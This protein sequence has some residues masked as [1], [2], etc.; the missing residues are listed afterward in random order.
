[1]T[2]HAYFAPS[3]SPRWLACPGSLK[4][5]EDIEES[6]SPYAHEGTVCH[7]VAARCLKE[8]LAAHDFTGC[9][10]E[11]VVM[12]RELLDG[13]QMYV[14][15]VRGMAKELGVKGGKIEHTVQIAEDCWGTIDAT[16]WNAEVLLVTDLKMGKGVIV[17]V[18]DNPQCKLYAVGQLMWLQKEHGL[19]P[20][21]VV[22]YII[23]PRTV[24]P[25][26]KWETT[27]QELIDWY[28]TTLKPTLEKIKAGDIECIPGETQCRWCPASA[29]CSV[30]AEYM[31]KETKEAFSPFSKTTA[32][33]VDPA[34]PDINIG[35]MADLKK[36][37]K[38]IQNW[39]GSIDGALMDLALGGENI[40]GFKLVRGRAN[41]KWV[42][43]ERVIEAFLLNNKVEP[44]KK[45]LVSP[46][47]AEKEFGKK[48]AKAAGFDKYI[49]TPPGKPTL[50]DESDKRPAMEQNVEKEFEQ[51]VESEIPSLVG[52]HTGERKIDDGPI[53]VESESSAMTLLERLARSDIPDDVL[54]PPSSTA[55][56]IPAI[57]AQAKARDLTIEDLFEEEK[58]EPQ[59]ESVE[60]VKAQLEKMSE[61]ATSGN[62]VDV[63][64]SAASTGK[65]KPPKTNTK[66]YQVL[67][68]GKGGV[69]LEDVAKALGCGINT[70]KMH[71]RYLHE[72]D[73]YGYEI[74]S[75]GTFKI[76]E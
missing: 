51:F 15:E 5:S 76:I 38:H 69:S 19:S 31:M 43:D 42:K 28:K 26:R 9:I 66:R 27:R 39:M 17:E 41:R 68:L 62:Q 50:V 21:K 71:I 25:L 32:P 52:A 74:Y 1:M 60:Q 70:V 56:E 30:Q 23:Q 13:I 49:T 45:E 6:T 58:A 53:I 72:R 35:E 36:V 3:A 73:G 29:V 11:K 44:W 57:E 75:N 63:M 34:N 64:Q 14:D 61:T 7:E 16:M 46:A 2:E 12:T 40:P 67:N 8:N 54:D 33:T 24:N 22:L 47:A 20:Q 48:N 4:M 65:A 37:F 55:A 18:E 10:I 59:V